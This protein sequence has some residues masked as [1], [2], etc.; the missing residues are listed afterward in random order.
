MIFFRSFWVGFSDQ[1]LLLRHNCVAQ[2]P[3][4]TLTGRFYAAAMLIRLKCGH[5]RW[6]LAICVFALPITASAADHL[7]HIGL[8]NQLQ[9]TDAQSG[10]N[11]TVVKPG[12]TVTWEWDYVGIDHSSTSGICPQNNCIPDNI[13]DSGLRFNPPPPPTFTRQFDTL[14][15]FPYFCRIHG[16]VGMRGKVVV[17]N[18]PDYELDI[19]N[20]SFTFPPSPIPVMNTVAG[21]PVNFSGTA[22]GFLGYS[23]RVNLN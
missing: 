9:F 16:P 12:D 11:V 20:N 14:G 17:L 3:R 2:L 5:W 15:T 13:W 22:F 7:V 21:Q 6:W 1:C 8:N 4:D 19:A 23:N 18:G 10:T